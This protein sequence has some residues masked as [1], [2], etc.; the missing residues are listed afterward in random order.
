MKK[1]FLHSLCGIVI[2]FINGLFGAGGG[3]IT[4]ILLERIL[5]FEPH[6]AHASTVAIIFCVTIVSSF[7]YVKNGIYDIPLTLKTAI[8]GI[9]G[10]I[11]GAKLLNKISEKYLHLIFGLFM[12]VA[13]VR[14]FMK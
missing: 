14:M 12:L 7:I 9:A 1:I 3:I 5:K 4:I 11:V 6:K 8:G 10:G 13:G 2:G